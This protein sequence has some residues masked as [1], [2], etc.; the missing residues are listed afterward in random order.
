MHRHGLLG[1]LPA[2]YIMGHGPIRKCF[3]PGATLKVSRTRVRAAAL[4]RIHRR[5][6]ASLLD[7]LPAL[8]LLSLLLLLPLLAACGGAAQGDLPATSD[9][10]GTP[11][12]APVDPT[13]PDDAPPD[14]TAPEILARASQRMAVTETVRF[15]LAIEGTT[16]IDPA[17]TIQLLGANGLLVRPDRMSSSF[18]AKVAGAI[19]ALKLITVGPTSW[20]TDLITGN[21]GIAPQEFGYEPNILFDNASGLGPVL[22]Q[23]QEPRLLATE[24]IRDRAA[25]HIAATVPRP[26]IDPVTAYTMSGDPV[27]VEVWI[28]QETGDLLRIKLVE[29]PSPENADP[30]TWVLNISDHGKRATIEPPL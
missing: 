7:R 16:F 14:L 2:A 28:D 21:W 30:A 12:A 22:L 5:K 9:T 26:I 25:H 29:P 3:P 4:V 11:L 1:T 20:M 8:R 6:D 10:S 17:R 19:V 27:A 23:L 15:Q 24:E 18:K 13:R